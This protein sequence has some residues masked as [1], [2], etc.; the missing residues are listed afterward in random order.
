[1]KTHSEWIEVRSGVFAVVAQFSFLVDVEAVKAGFQTVNFSA[2]QN[3]LL[4]NILNDKTYF[5]FSW[6]LNNKKQNQV[7]A[8]SY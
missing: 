4:R 5:I 6:F 3:T 2:Q 8:E 7:L 1:M